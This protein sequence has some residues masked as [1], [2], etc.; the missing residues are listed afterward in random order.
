MKKIN[1][2]KKLTGVLCLAL[3]GAL[4][5]TGCTKGKNNDD[6]SDSQSGNSVS[7][8]SDISTPV[9]NTVDVNCIYHE[10]GSFSLP[11]G[12][13]SDSNINVYNDTVYISARKYNQQTY[14]IEDSA[15]FTFDTDGNQKN[16]ISF[17]MKTNAYIAGNMTFDK[18][19]NLC[20]IECEYT[21]PESDGGDAEIMPKAADDV[22]LAAEETAAEDDDTEDSAAEDDIS[23]DE[24]VA[25]DDIAIDDDTSV[26]DDMMVDDY[27]ETYT[28]IKLDSDGNRIF[29]KK[30]E[31]KNNKDG[32]FY[33]GSLFT[34]SDGN[35]YVG[36]DSLIIILDSEGNEKGT[37]SS[38]DNGISYIEYFV[39]TKDNKPLA[40]Y[41]DAEW[42]GHLSEIDAEKCSF[43]NDYD[44]EQSDYNIKKGSGQ[45]DLM[46]FNSTEMLGYNLETGEATKLVDWVDSDINAANLMTVEAVADNKFIISYYDTIESITKMT[47]IEKTNPEDVKNQQII[48]LAGMYIDSDIYSYITRF[49]KENDNYRIKVTDYSQY[50]TD[51]ED[52]W[53]AGQKKFN[54]DMAVGKVPDIIILNQS[55]PVEML[56]SKG[57]LADI[58]P[59]MEKDGEI[60][61]DDLLPNVIESCTIDGKLYSIP[62]AFQ[63]RTLAG[64]TSNLDGKTGWNISEFIEFAENLDEGQSLMREDMFFS[65][66]II[67]TLLQSSMH[68]FVNYSEKSCSFDSEDFIKILEFANQF[69]KSEEYYADME[70]MSDDEW[71]KMYEEMEMSYRNN[72]TVLEDTYI[73]DPSALYNTEKGQFGD[74]VTFIGYPTDSGNGSSITTSVEFAVSAKSDNQD[75]AWEFIKQFL[76][77]DYQEKQWFGLPVRKEAL[78]KKF[79]DAMTPYTYTDE[80]GETVEEENYYYFGNNQINIGYMD[81]TYKEKY[82]NFILSVNTKISCDEEIFSI[83][84]EETEAYFSGQKPAKDVADIIQNRVKTYINENM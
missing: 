16:K 38:E 27:S 30:I 14:E 32:Y 18:D 12:Y 6:S 19:G 71:N 76:T 65:D 74:D 11:E 50:N 67:S 10:A 44:F 80:N 81:E 15:L 20:Y 28:L 23:S 49:N 25:D 1:L 3:A 75:G 63:I 83:I 42:K 82:I 66:T 53:M 40:F 17:D 59:F 70:D 48:T 64:K 33:V 47:I 36:S 39:A 51:D 24:S 55:M 4:M 84:N 72:K 9:S 43:G 26:D 73:Y 35:F 69:P 2:K 58:T 62:A 78:D 13:E 61:A 41:H 7:D 29:E 5:L 34:D 60:K 45:Y 79:E 54:A 8:S 46:L 21:V 77:E 31:P 52:G 22:V 68:S 37:I 57:I 56:A